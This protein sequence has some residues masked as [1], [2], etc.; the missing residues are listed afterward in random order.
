MLEKKKNKGI[1][2]LGQSRSGGLVITQKQGKSQTFRIYYP[3][4]P[5][6]I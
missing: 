2:K 3:T 6:N 1:L 5:I 4:F